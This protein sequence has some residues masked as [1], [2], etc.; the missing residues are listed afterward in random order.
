MRYSLRL[1]FELFPYKLYRQFFRYSV[2]TQVN[3]IPIAMRLLGKFIPLEY[4]V[5]CP[6]PWDATTLGDNGTRKHSDI[7]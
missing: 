6:I 3:G 2:F 5:K 4:Q 7:F 1:I